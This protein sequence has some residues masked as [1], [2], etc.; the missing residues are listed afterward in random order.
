MAETSAQFEQRKK[1]HIRIALDPQS[2]AAGMSELESVRLIHEALPEFNFSEVSTNCS[3]LSHELKFPLFISSMTAGHIEG[4]TINKK[5]A[6]AVSRR[7]WAMGVGSQRK[8]L[9]DSLAS[10]EWK[11]IRQEAPDAIMIGN[12]GIA[13]IIQNKVEHIQALVDNLQASALFVHLNP[14]QEILQKEGTPD[15]K[16]GLRA[17]EVLCETLKVP[18]IIKE[19]GCG[20]SAATLLKL[21]NLG[22]FAV[23][24]AGLGG[25]HWGRIEGFRSMPGDILYES[26]QTFKDWG[27]S[28]VESLLMAKECNPD[29][30]VWASGGV[31]S[32]LDAAK[33]LVLGAQ[34]VGIA[35]PLLEAAI[36]SEEALEK[37]MEQFEFELKIAMFCTGCENLQALTTKRVW[38]WI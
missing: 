6:K 31:R 35:K 28:T 8:E 14:L 36:L 19:V 2:Q 37:T 38:K 34:M 9:T 33:L 23:D 25:T 13:Q 17:I 21:K 3:V 20:F 10:K 12:L 24:V 18:V 7:G 11:A 15:F 30:K 16:G 1:D 4:D 22:V 26:A 5:L 27:I 32:G 29:Y